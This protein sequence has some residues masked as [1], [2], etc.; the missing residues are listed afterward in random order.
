MCRVMKINSG[1]YYKWKKQPIGRRALEG[2]HLK[3]AITRVF[4]VSD[5]TY[6]S[7]RIRQELKSEGFVVSR[8]RVAK[9]MKEEGLQSKIRKQWKVTTNSSH[10]YSV[11]QN[12][13]A[14]NFVV[15]RPDEVWVS[16]ITYIKT[17]QGWLYL[18]VVIDLWDRAVVGWSLSKTMFTKDTV[19]PAW[20]MAH[21]NRN[22]TKPLL[23][24]SD[25][26]IQYACKAFTNYLKSNRLVKQ[27]MSRKGN[28]WDN[29]VAESFFKTI[30]TELIYHHKYKTRMEAELKI[31]TYIETW[32][33]RKRR[34][35]ALNGKSILEFNQINNMKS[36]A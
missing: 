10:R 31:F 9:L 24:H 23:F 28:C 17:S 25:R 1:C 3:L 33:N 29:A 8:K 16:D 26:G 36:A 18:T 30:K 21:I 19:I 7:P 4:K 15:S 11:A 5:K 22:I 14:Q 27:S 32:Y 6:G 20:K 34:H 13:L 2:V 35:S 12:L